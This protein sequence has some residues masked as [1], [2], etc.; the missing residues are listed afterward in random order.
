MRSRSVP[1]KKMD[2]THRSR[3]SSSK[4]QYK[5]KVEIK[6]KDEGAAKGPHTE[7]RI[8]RLLQQKK[9]KRK[10][11]DSEETGTHPCDITIISMQGGRAVKQCKVSRCER[12]IGATAV[13]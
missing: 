10:T 2:V 4:P 11:T 13:R 3:L 5:S 9:G 7:L 6:L 1:Y 8:K 12:P